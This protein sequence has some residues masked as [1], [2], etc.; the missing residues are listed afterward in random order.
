ME[1]RQTFTL[2]NLHR[3]RLKNSTGYICRDGPRCFLPPYPSLN[4]RRFGPPYL[5]FPDAWSRE[6]QRIRSS[7][8]GIGLE[9]IHKYDP[10]IP[11]TCWRCLRD[12]GTHYHIFWECSLILP[13]WSSVQSV[14]QSRPSPLLVRPPS[15]WN[16][17]TC[18]KM[19]VI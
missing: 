11:Q 13:F 12:I 7:C 10:S 4:G 8:S 15:P 2:Q 18:Q 16:I 19:Y 6:R 17:Q 14:L 5:K 3:Q 1:W 9:V